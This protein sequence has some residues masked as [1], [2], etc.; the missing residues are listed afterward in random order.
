MRL[1]YKCL[2]CGLVNPMGSITCQA[3]G[4]SLTGAPPAITKGIPPF[5]HP[6]GLAPHSTQSTSGS[7]GTL[8]KPQTT[9]VATPVVSSTSAPAASRLSALDPFG[10]KSLDGRVIQVE[11]LY[12]GTP[13]SRWVQSLVKLA[14]LGAA[15]YIYGALLL[16]LLVVLVGVAWLVAKVLRGGFLSS[17]AV[18]VTSFILTRRLLGPVAN[19]PIRDI[20]LRDSNGQETLVR[21]KGQLVSGS[22]TVGDDVH[23]EGWERGGMLLFRRGYNNRI[24]AAIQVKR[25]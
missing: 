25:A 18:Q 20:R 16:V 14:I 10:W 22:V 5:A 1:P 13:D 24:R 9:S 19:V 15:V 6:S 21:M 17:V 23:V 11:P 7:Q 8:R 4:A 2:R 3:C 12:M